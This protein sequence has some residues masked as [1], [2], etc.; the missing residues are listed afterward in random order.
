[1]WNSETDQ[2]KEKTE[3]EHVMA[4]D[5]NSKAKASIG[6]SVTVK[7]EITGEEDI[8]VEGY[9]EG[10]V[11]LKKNAVTVASTG[12]VKAHI[13]AVTVLVEGEVTGDIDGTEKVVVCKSGKVI[14]NITAPR[15]TIED[16]A[17]IK[18]SMSTEGVTGDTS[19]NAFKGTKSGTTID[20][21]DAEISPSGSRKSAFLKGKEVDTTNTSF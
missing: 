17:K 4:I 15:I 6:P 12:K 7:G 5:S 3:G 14:G 13:F 2:N 11:N 8:L 10:T 16:G 20:E 9:V 21:I 1:M 19:K 18:G